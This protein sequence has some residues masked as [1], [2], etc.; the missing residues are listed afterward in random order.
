MQEILAYNK[1]YGW[2]TSENGSLS[3]TRTV[4]FHDLS[5]LEDNCQQTLLRLQISIRPFRLESSRFP[6]RTTVSQPFL[7][8]KM[9]L[10]SQDL[11]RHCLPSFNFFRPW[12][13]D[14][15]W[16]YD[17]LRREEG[18]TTPS[19]YNY[20]PREATTSSSTSEPSFVTGT[21]QFSFLWHRLRRLSWNKYTTRLVK[22]SIKK[23]TGHEAITCL[24][25]TWIMD[26]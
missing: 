25:K 12:I 1:M 13:P 24:M 21:K 9:S 10:W 5:Y 2:Q 16:F 26:D 22:T 19:P 4:V 6:T 14:L 3:F 11:L 15:K 23:S 17:M 8:R 7:E 20:R 18:Y